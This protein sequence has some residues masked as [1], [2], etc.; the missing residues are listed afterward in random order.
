MIDWESTCCPLCL[1]EKT[2]LF[3][4]R[5]G[6]IG[7]R[8][9]HICEVCDLVF[10]PERFHLGWREQLER[11]RSHN[12]HLYD[13]DYREFLSRLFDQLL[14]YVVPGHSALDYGSGPGPALAAMMS[15]A[16]LS[17]S[18]YD[19]FFQPDESPLDVRYD[20]VTCTE[21][22][23]HFVK[24]SVDF[25]KLD[26]VLNPSGWLGVMTGMLD[27][28]DQFKDWYYHKDPTHISFYSRRTMMW[29]AAK[30]S[31]KS[32]FPRKNVVLFNK[33]GENDR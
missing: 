25:D 31:W 14:P 8:D 24:P 3:Y 1:Q 27:S 18:T 10:V 30:Y 16:G 19:P 33:G 6:S 32:F 22:A 21:T 20:I 13:R 7:E 4:V 5:R 2:A 9:F 29:I 15:E 26:S 12:N 11:Y 17:V 28:W 23:E